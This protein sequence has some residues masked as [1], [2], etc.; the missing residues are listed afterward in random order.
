MK[1]QKVKE[2]EMLRRGEGIFFVD[3]RV[4]RLIPNMRQIK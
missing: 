4:I 3:K 1:T 2:D